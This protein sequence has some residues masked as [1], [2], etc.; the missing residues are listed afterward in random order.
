[1]QQTCEFSSQHLSPDVK[2]RS[3]VKN[4]DH[5]SEWVSHLSSFPGAKWHA[6]FP[7]LQLLSSVEKP[8]KGVNC[9]TVS[10]IF[11]LSLMSK[12]THATFCKWGELI[13][14]SFAA[15]SET[16]QHGIPS[17][18]VCTVVEFALHAQHVL[19][20]LL[21]SASVELQQLANFS[22]I[23]IFYDNFV[24]AG[25][26]AWL[27]VCFCCCWTCVSF[28]WWSNFLVLFWFC[29]FF[30]VCACLFHVAC[31]LSFVDFPF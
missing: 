13:F 27:V 6:Q 30:N 17:N 21:L 8:S 15:W 12:E 31:P 25:A 29:K 10:E 18:W 9:E 23:C 19:C 4:T 16:W 14:A 2:T 7:W 1:M 24:I 5:R 11:D 20:E 28:S 26:E 3:S 22:N